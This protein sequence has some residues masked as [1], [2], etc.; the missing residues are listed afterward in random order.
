MCLEFLFRS[1]GHTASSEEDAEEWRPSN[2]K[3]KDTTK[4]F[5]DPSTE[6]VKAPAKRIAKPKEPKEPRQPK[7]PKVPREPKLKVPRRA[8]VGRKTQ[9]PAVLKDSGLGAT[10]IKEDIVGEAKLNKM[11]DPVMKTTE[12]R[13]PSIRMKEEVWDLFFLFDNNLY[14]NQ[15]KKRIVLILFTILFDFLILET[16]HVIGVEDSVINVT[17]DEHNKCYRCAFCSCLTLCRQCMMMITALLTSR[18]VVVS[19]VLSLFRFLSCI[20]EAVISSGRSPI[21]GY[22]WWRIL[23]ILAATKEGRSWRFY[24]WW[25]VPKE[26]EN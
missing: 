14:L 3:Q 23:T 9:A 15:N 17:C 12:E 26:A 18:N 8:A 11:D 2:S 7:I 13:V 6:K 5:G 25:A 22:C 4:L 16:Q 21:G 20:L 24:I 10:K 19:C 1:F